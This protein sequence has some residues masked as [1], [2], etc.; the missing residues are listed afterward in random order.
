M[1]GHV[2]IQQ[3]YSTNFDEVDPESAFPIQVSTSGGAGSIAGSNLDSSS[4]SLEV[5]Q[6]PP[7]PLPYDS[8]P[9][10]LRI[11]RDGL[12]S[13]RD[14]SG[15][16][17]LGDAHPLRHSNS[18]GGGGTAL[19]RRY[20]NGGGVDLEEQSQGL[21]LGEKSAISSKAF[22]R[23]E[24]NL[25]MLDDDDVCPTCLDGIVLQPYSFSG[26]VLFL[27]LF[28]C[29]PSCHPLRLLSALYGLL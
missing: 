26:L 25:S 28:R 24:S 14:K 2:C 1:L 13:R 16:S 22:P 5:F 21:K 19:Q 11:G 20:G 10:Y 29:L 12:I 3:H 27:N 18:D 6:A 17:H 4:S 23:V 9:R 7:T 15:V 8:D